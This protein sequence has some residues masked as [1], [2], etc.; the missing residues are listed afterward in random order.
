MKLILGPELTQRIFRIN[1]L[2]FLYIILYIE[3]NDENTTS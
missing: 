3:D 2:I 1:T